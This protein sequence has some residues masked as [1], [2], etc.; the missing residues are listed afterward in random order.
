M[1]LVGMDNSHAVIFKD[2]K[3]LSEK[4]VKLVKTGKTV[5]ALAEPQAKKGKVFAGWYTDTKLTNK[6][7][8]KKTVERDMKLYPKWV[9]AGSVK[10]TALRSIVKKGKSIKVVLKK[11]DATGYEVKLS[12]NKNFKSAK[13]VKGHSTGITVKG[14]KAK[15]VYFIKARAYKV[16]EGKTIYGQYTGKLRI[17]L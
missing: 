16:I 12:T 15:K 7:D 11:I 10:S 17:R 8:F 1:V 13:T 5:K 14:L 9:D 2:G 3:K 4:N 6:W